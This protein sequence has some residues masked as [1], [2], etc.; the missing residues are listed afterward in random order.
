MTGTRELRIAPAMERV[1]GSRPPGVYRAQPAGLAAPSELACA[2]RPVQLAGGDRL[3]GVGQHQLVD[4]RLLRKSTRTASGG[5]TTQRIPIPPGLPTHVMRS[6]MACSFN[7][8]CSRRTSVRPGFTA[9]TAC[10]FRAR[11]AAAVLPAYLRCALAMASTLL[12]RGPARHALPGSIFSPSVMRRSSASS[13]CP[14]PQYRGCPITRYACTEGISS[15][16]GARLLAGVPLVACSARALS[17]RPACTAGT[18]SS[19]GQ[20]PSEIQPLGLEQQP[21][22][23]VVPGLAGPAFCA[24]WAREAGR[25]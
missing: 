12:L 9:C 19:D 13:R 5:C 4:D 8:Y 20:L 18:R 2:M 23:Q 16:R 11:R 21:V 15:R 1:E 10:S 3:N 17:A 24:R 22:V 14:T 7:A 6:F 25:P